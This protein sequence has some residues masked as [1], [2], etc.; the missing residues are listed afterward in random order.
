MNASA[1]SL[2]CDPV[3]LQE[4]LAE[5]NISIIGYVYKYVRWV[6]IIKINQIIL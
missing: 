2:K 5:V 1:F 6:R 4:T 3:A